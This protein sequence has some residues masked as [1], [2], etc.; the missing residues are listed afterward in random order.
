MGVLCRDSSPACSL[1]FF[2]W[3]CK[4]EGAR[5]RADNGCPVHPPRAWAP[6]MA[7]SSSSWG[8][9]VGTVWPVVPHMGPTLGPVCAEKA[10]AMWTHGRTDRLPGMDQGSP[11]SKGT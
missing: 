5:H 2:T 9:G 3:L 10:R 1:T 6:G 8:A 7:C 11:N 4:R